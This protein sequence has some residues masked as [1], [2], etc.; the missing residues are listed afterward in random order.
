MNQIE[1]IRDR[2]ARGQQRELVALRQFISMTPGNNDVV[3]RL[4]DKGV[5]VLLAKVVDLI[6]A[7]LG[8]ATKTPP[9]DSNSVARRAAGKR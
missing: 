7:E 5:G 9:S 2:I 8:H 1:L 3:D 6:M 4:R